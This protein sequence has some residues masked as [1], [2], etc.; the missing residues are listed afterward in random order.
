MEKV[1]ILKNLDG[2]E[3]SKL[4][5]AFTEHWFQDGDCII[6]EGDTE[7]NLFFL[8]MEGAAFATKITEP[9]KPAEV[10]KKYQP[11]GY[12]GERALL[13]DEP[14]AASIIADGEACVVSLDRAAFKRLLGPIENILGRNEAEYRKWMH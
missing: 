9:G 12:F 4:C 3:R 13:K 5:D 7:A 10:V 11:G 2:D 1:D 14:R 8:I 6:R